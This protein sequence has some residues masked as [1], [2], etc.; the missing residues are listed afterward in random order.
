MLEKEGGQIYKW[1]N[2]LLK[3]RNFKYHEATLHISNA[4]KLENR[5]K[6]EITE[7][8]ETKMNKTDLIRV[9]KLKQANLH[10]ES[11]Y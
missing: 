6:V 1:G 4:N 3:K 2:N 10:R 8:K 7:G 5:S 9:I 11:H